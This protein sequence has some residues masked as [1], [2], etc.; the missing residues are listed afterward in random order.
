M[1]E[2]NQSIARATNKISKSH[3]MRAIT[4]TASVPTLYLLKLFTYIRRRKTKEAQMGDGSRWL[5]AEETISLQYNAM[6]LLSL[7][8]S[9]TFLLKVFLHHDAPL[10][11]GFTSWRRRHIGHL[12][13]DDHNVRNM[14]K[15]W[16]HMLRHFQL[17]RCLGKKRKK[18]SFCLLYKTKVTM[19][20]TSLCCALT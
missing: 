6:R 8:F 14:I 3:C 11:L 2:Q 16:A 13:K 5:N 9:T 10:F 17:K 19:H 15:N 1:N 18:Y 12:H 4:L 7:L 20:S